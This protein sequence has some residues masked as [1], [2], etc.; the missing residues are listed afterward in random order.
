M[1]QQASKYS[2]FVFCTLKYKMCSYC[3]YS[4]LS[5]VSYSRC[6]SFRHLNFTSQFVD[7]LGNGHIYE[8]QKT[9]A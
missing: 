2:H 6:T 7:V 4:G 8:K 9:F 5:V 1:A 3:R